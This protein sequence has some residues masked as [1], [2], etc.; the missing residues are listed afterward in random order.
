MEDNG[1]NGRGKVQG[2]EAGPMTDIVPAKEPQSQPPAGWGKHGVQLNSLNEAWRFAKMLVESGFAPKGINTPAACL[3]ALQAGAE[4]DLLPFAAMQTIAVI[5]GRPGLF[6]DGA[7]A[8]VQ[9]S[10]F[11]DH[12]AFE[13]TISNDKNGIVAT[14]TVRRLPHG[15]PVTRSWS[16][17]DAK[18]AGLLGKPGPWSQYPAR[19]CQWRA[20]HWAMRDAFADVLKGM[21]VEDAPS[22]DLVV[23]Q[24][25]GLDDLAAQ[26]EAKA[27]AKKRR[28]KAAPVQETI[29]TDTGE[30][31]TSATHPV[32]TEYTGASDA[33]PDREP[34]E[35]G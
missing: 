30:V 14:C 15:K 34:G 7:L 23:E 18:L 12:S 24:V 35:E 33:W 28:A 27:P 32:E 10:K 13:E 9:G 16:L 21:A 6:G 31:T 1:E 20:R 2:T 25:S 26:M 29:D 8:V 19:M 17:A 4:V 5:N 3:I 22:K 11:F